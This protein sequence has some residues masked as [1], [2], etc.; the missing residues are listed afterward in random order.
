MTTEEIAKNADLSGEAQAVLRPEMAPAQYVDALEKQGLFQDAVRFLACKMA[1]NVAIRWGQTCG[2]ELAPPNPDARAEPAMSA[3]A[4]WLQTP[5]D[6][7][8]RQ[9]REAADKSGVDTAAG[10]LAMAVALSGGSITPPGAPEIIP[11]PYTAN[12]LV[13]TSIMVAVL[14]YQPEKAAERYGK[15]LAIGR[16]LD[17]G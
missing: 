8:R 9:A 5:D 14:G 3:T 13:A 1:V 11:P 6:S 10:C 4:R 7:S 16:G 12:K 17:A 2:K 15:A